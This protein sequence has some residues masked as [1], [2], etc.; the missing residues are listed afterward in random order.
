MRCLSGCATKATAISP[1]RLSRMPND[2]KRFR[3]RAM[4]CRNLAK[5]AHNQID[6]EMLE[7]IAADLDEEARKIEAEQVEAPR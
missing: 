5:G 3:D 6:R 1:I 4:D 7:E 2:A